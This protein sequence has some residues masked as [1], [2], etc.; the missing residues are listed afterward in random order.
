MFVCGIKGRRWAW[1]N[2]EDKVLETFLAIQK[3]WDIAGKILF[4]IYLAMFLLYTILIT[5]SISAGFF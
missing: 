4:F 2:Y 1:E 5:F 3:T